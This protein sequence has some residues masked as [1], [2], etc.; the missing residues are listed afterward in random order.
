MKKAT[1]FLTL[2]AVTATVPAQQSVLLRLK[3]KPGQ[4]FKYTMRMQGSGTQ[5]MNMAM[6]MSMKVTSV[7]NKQFTT[8][9]S[10]G[11][12]TMN[13]QP[14]PPQ[15]AEQMKKMLI[16][17]VMDERGRVLKTEM[18][19]IPGAPS[20]GGM[21]GS[22]V[23]FPAGPIKIGQSWS[24]EAT[25]QGQKVQT[26][27]KL[28]GLKPVAG[29]PAAVIHATPK[30]MPQMTLDGPIVFSVELATGFPLSM[31]MSGTATRGNQTQK[32]KMTMNRT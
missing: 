5:A 21:E 24:G 30:N 4:N 28:V 3:A 14:L 27:Y 32:M 7:K 12:I 11:S 31:S 15:A 8:N 22:S 6:Q 20:G 25:L 26:T 2:L 23:P 13:N 19:G 16:V 9:T 17:T 1:L 29:R 18:K 10:M